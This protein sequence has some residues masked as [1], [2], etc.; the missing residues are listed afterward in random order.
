MK[1]VTLL[2]LL[3]DDTQEICL[4]MKKRGFGEGKF[5]GVGGKIESGETA[6]AA[7]IR[8]TKEEIGVDVTQEDLIPVATISFLYHKYKPEWPD[9]R[10]SVFFTK[11]WRGEPQESEE[12]RPQWYAMDALPF[13]SMWPDDP[14]WLPRALA[15]ERLVCDFYFDSEA[16][17]IVEHTVTTIGAQRTYGRED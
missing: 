6:E 15:G 4:A 14:L 8:E 2:F 13:E 17:K 11:A 7:A 10:C 3:K 5:N 12:M 1:H 9:L 16:K